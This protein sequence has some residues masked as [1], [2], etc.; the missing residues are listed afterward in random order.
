[1]DGW[2]GVATTG[3]TPPT[4]FGLIMCTDSARGVGGEMQAGV[5]GGG[6]RLFAE[7]IA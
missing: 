7:L 4:E 6:L 5:E 3:Q 1:M 2:S